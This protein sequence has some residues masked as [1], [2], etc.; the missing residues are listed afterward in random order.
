MYSI[1][2]FQ[3][4]F[5]AKSSNQMELEG[6]FSVLSLFLCSSFLPLKFLH[7]LT[8]QCQRQCHCH[9]HCFSCQIVTFQCQFICFIS[10]VFARIRL[11]CAQSSVHFLTEQL[12]QRRKVSERECD[13]YKN[14]FYSHFTFF[15]LRLMFC[16]VDANQMKFECEANKEI[17]CLSGARESSKYIKEWS[18]HKMRWA[19][20]LAHTTFL[21][22]P[23][24]LQ[25]E[26]CI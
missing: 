6:D 1:K 4:Y 8:Q 15:F 12:S 20:A 16:L 19:W 26:K 7:L 18:K 10:S 2:W 17:T 24:L 13:K 3:K 25:T 22:L 21:A 5:H 9:C 11:L 14:C 23:F